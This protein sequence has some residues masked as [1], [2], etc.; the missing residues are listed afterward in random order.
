M[1]NIGIY[2]VT[3]V[4]FGGRLDYNTSAGSNTDALFLPKKGITYNISDHDFYKDS[5]INNI[6][7]NIKVRANYGESSNFAQPF[8]QDKTFALESFLGAPAFRFD[9]PGNNELVSEIVVT[10]EFRLDLGFLNNRINLSGTYYKAVTNDTLITPSQPPSSGLLAQVQNI[11]EIQNTGWEFAINTTIVQTEK[12]NLKFNFS[13][14]TNDN[15]WKS[16][17]GAPAFNVGGFSVIGSWIEEGQS[18]GY[19][20]GTY[21]FTPNAALGDTFAPIF[22][23][24]GLNYTWDKLDFFVTGDYQFG[25]KI[26]DLNFL[27]RH[28]R[29]VDDTGVPNDLVGATSPFNYVNYFTF[30]NDYVKIRNIGLTYNFGKALRVFENVHLG[31][32]VTNLLNWTAGTFDPETTGSGISAQNGFNSGGFTYGTE[33]APRIFMT[34]LKFKFTQK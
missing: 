28:L 10:N 23:S 13:Y 3:F 32:T 11:G 31:V 9:Q 15:F 21:K 8:S 7:S 29:G 30:D 18:L 12:H 14:N 26:V 34:S 19:L 4:K 33:S 20:R 27:L 24:F 16:S 17:D 2:D 5:E 1:K 25:G 22:G 6:I